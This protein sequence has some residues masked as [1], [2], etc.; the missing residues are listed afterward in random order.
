MME[1]VGRRL[2]TKDGFLLDI[3]SHS[4]NGR[5]RNVL[6]RNNG[7][8]TFTEVGWINGADRIED[9]RGLAI[10]DYDEDGRLDAVLRN[11]RVPATLLHNKGAVRHWVQL[12][13]VGTQSNRD[14][15]GARVRLRTGDQWQTRIVTAGSG[16]LSGSSKRIHFGLGA[17][18]RV[19]EVQI[20]WPS[21]QKT[22]LQDLGADQRYQVIEGPEAVAT[23]VPSRINAT[24]AASP[25]SG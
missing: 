21:G 5:E 15:V 18:S 22:R 11:Y 10:L 23:P 4:L 25:R 7:D 3:G 14:A 6:F 17:V 12:E 8:D 2:G 9:G 20:D 1:G 24:A 19:D 13:L 16:Y